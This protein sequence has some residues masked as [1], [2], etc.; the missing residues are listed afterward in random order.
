VSAT[1]GSRRL[2][3]IL[4]ADVVGYS[5]MVAA[6][7]PGTL[8]RLRAARRDVVDPMMAEFKGRVFKVMGDG[9]LA[10]FPSAVQA[11][12][13]A[14]AIQQRLRGGDGLQVRIGLHQGDVVAEGGDLLGDGVNVAARLEA[15]AEPGGIC[16]SAR[17][18]EDAVGKIP[19]DVEDIGTPPL[20]NIAQSVH[21]FRVRL[22]APERPALALPDKPSI[23]VLPFQNMSGDPEQEYFA[24]GMVEEII[25]A[26]SRI[27]WLF[28][29]ARNST[30]TYKG[31]AI[32]VKRV[33]RELGVRYVLEGSVRKSS[34]RVRITA[35]LIE[36]EIGVHLWANRFD[37]SLEDV[38]TFQDEV[39]T[40][41][42]G[43]I[44]P[45]LHSSEIRR[46]TR[47]R[48]PTSD[49][50]AYDLCLR[51]QPL[52]WS[53][54]KEG[55]LQ[56]LGLLEVAIARDPQYG[57]AF[58]WAAICRWHLWE[59]WGD[60]EESNRRISMEYAR[61]ALVLGEDDAATLANA[62]YALA[63]QGDIDTML[64]IVDR[65]LALQPSFARGGYISGN[66]KMWARDYDAAIERVETSLRLSPR[67]R[68]GTQHFL[69]GLAY[70]CKRQFDRAAQHLK[71]AVQEHPGAPHITRNLAACY[72]H[73]GRLAEAREMFE[74][75]RAMGAPI[76]HEQSRGSE[77][78]N[79]IEAGLRLAMGQ[80]T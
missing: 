42:A 44:E 23:A 68:V 1:A 10:E 16:I 14:I 38:F 63:A 72:A 7:E 25:T 11:L 74:R 22:D 40:N 56:A 64:G 39:A 65:A 19:L 78:E 15:L 51:A 31:Q 60:D 43:A 54:G 29:I 9:L 6:D 59:F 52:F 28:V 47:T 48:R 67:A 8:A 45:T 62:A 24:D 71:M 61:R 75:V 53:L 5:R 49:L 46:A 77:H 79:L 30:F 18:R 21:V 80:E 27:H 66:L 73:M 57:P 4:A 34:G 2:A 70:L 76:I 69:L 36:A 26:L 58:A 32:D 37:G 35:Q 41:V 33:G 17:V 3:A 50:A 12:R 13:C 20:K 55:V